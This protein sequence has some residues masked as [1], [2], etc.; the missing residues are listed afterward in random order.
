MQPST[1][2]ISTP[3]HGRSPAR[4][5][6]TDRGAEGL[7]FCW[8]IGSLA[9]SCIRNVYE[10]NTIAVV[11]C[12]IPASH[13]HSC[14]SYS[15]ETMLQDGGNSA[16]TGRWDNGSTFIDG[17]SDTRRHRQG[18]RGH[19]SGHGGRHRLGSRCRPQGG[20]RRDSAARRAFD[21]GPWPRMSPR[22][23]AAVLSRVAN[24]LD[25]RHD[26]LKADGGPARWAA[27]PTSFRSA[28]LST[29][30]NGSPG[31][32]VRGSVDRGLSPRRRVRRAPERAGPVARGNAHP[33]S[34]ATA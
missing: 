11:E 7:S 33:I 18:R 4:L 3:C 8:T 19:R 22:Q 31:H 16:V 28:A 27:S 2:P 32:A 5:I 1:L 17:A 25:E 9:W 14:R 29:S 20:T 23:R 10:M 12:T 13:S 26:A 30:R 34:G 21:D 15:A 24:I 6:A